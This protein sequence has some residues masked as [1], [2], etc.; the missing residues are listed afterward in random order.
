M[1]ARLSSP[2]SPPT[3]SSL[4]Q[5]TPWLRLLPGLAALLLGSVL[6]PAQQT[7]ARP[8]TVISL[9]APW[10][11]HPGSALPN[12]IDPDFDDTAWPQLTPNQPLP[13]APG[14]AWAR[15]HLH[16]TGP[17]TPLGLALETRS[18]QQ[19][20]VFANGHFLGGSP[21]VAQGYQQRSTPTVFALPPAPDIVLAVHLLPRLTMVES[22]FPL[23]SVRLGPHAALTDRVALERLQDLDAEWLTGIFAGLV[24]LSFVPIAFTLFIARRD[25]REYLWLALFC[26][27]GAVYSFLATADGT[28]TLP[29]NIPNKILF[30]CTGWFTLIA[31]LEFVRTFVATRRHI[32]IRIA[33]SLFAAAP[34]VFF[35][36]WYVAYD[37]VLAA[38]MV[39]WI[40]IVTLYLVAAYRRGQAES[41]LLLAPFAFI[42]LFT[43][44]GILATFFPRVFPLTRRV[45]LGH[46]GVGLDDLA[47]I[48]F[49]FGILAIVLFRFVRVSRDE[50]R[51]AA[52]LEAARNLQQ[53]LIPTSASHSE[54]LPSIHGYRIESAYHPARE[55]GGD[56]FQIIPLSSQQSALVILGDVSGKGLQAA[57]TVALI[58]GALRALAEHTQSPAGLLAG[59]NRLLYGRGS[60]FTTCVI[61]CL[62]AE[63]HLL[64]AN[65]GHLPPYLQGHELT[66]PPTLPLGILPEAT[67]ID[68]PV[69]LP[70]GATLTL[71]T[72][73][74]V[75]ATHPTTRELF[76]FDR[77]RHLS[78]QPA[79]YIADAARTF[80]PPNA[81]DD[82]LTVLTI[83]RTASP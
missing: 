73:G 37:V 68:T 82:D 27:V 64:A 12:V 1:S 33:Q 70:P 53:V 24:Y 52:E 29:E 16:L 3:S 39:L 56:F 72:D 2:L 61:F 58:V 62:G 8:Q 80:G 31:G 74:V 38:G 28:G 54:D 57:M 25:R 65:A 4:R 75:E 46:I 66:L 55:V 69:T 36:H 81:Q 5:T 21:G 44:V 15:L 47:A 63:G 42:P 13:T 20:V 11:V 9:T 77:T 43:L 26:L 83:T 22:R 18:G 59:L 60:G 71:L 34:L 48:L 41:G 49:I 6:L 19:F 35:L 23:S 76:G 32:P 40:V 10:H 79:A 14:D 17:P 67:F 7:L 78:T 50:Q 51:A 30:A 45:R